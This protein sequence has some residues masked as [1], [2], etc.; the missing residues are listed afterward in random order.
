MKTQRDVDFTGTMFELYK[1]AKSECGYNAIRYLAM[2]TDHGELGTARRLL[3][4]PTASDGYTALWQAGRLYLTVE[5]VALLPEWSDLITEDDKAIT[6]RRL[7]E[8]AYFGGM[9]A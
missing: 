8:H 4:A 5:A 2:V 1:R 6:R 9:P 7:V 3:H